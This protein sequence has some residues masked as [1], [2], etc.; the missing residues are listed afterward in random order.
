[1]PELPEVETVCRGLEKAVKGKVFT[2]ITLRRTD[3]R[4]PLPKQKLQNLCGQSILGLERRAKYI[5][6]NFDNGKTILLH[7]GMSGRLVIDDGKAELEKHDH[8]VFCCSN[9]TRIRFNDA[10]R[11]GMLDVAPTAAI[12]QHKLLKKLGV[13]PFSADFNAKMLHEKLQHKTAAIKLAIMDQALVVGV[14]NIYAS[15]ALF[16]SGI[17][18]RRTAGSLSRKNVAALVAAIQDVLRRAI[19]KGGSSLRDY[20]QADGEL[21]T[22]QHAFAVYDRAGLRCPDCACDFSKTGGIQRMVQ[23]GRSTFF[24]ARKQR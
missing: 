24:C 16:Q 6:I 10:R 8:V 3:L 4:F 14:G 2:D 11:F 15:E 21:G 23:G 17:D 19:A 1:M 12:H 20:K 5:L 18:P 22:F 13:E 7:L 9:G